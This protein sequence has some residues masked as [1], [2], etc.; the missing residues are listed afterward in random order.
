VTQRGLW[1]LAVG[2][3]A[4][5]VFVGTCLG[6]RIAVSDDADSRWV[7]YLALAQSMLLFDT[8]VIVVV[9]TAAAWRQVEVLQVQRSDQNKPLVLTQGSDSDFTVRNIGPGAAVNVYVVA[10][11]G[12]DPD[13][14]EA[15]LIGALGAGGEVRPP[16]SY[17]GTPSPWHHI[18]ISEALHSRTQQWQ[19]SLNVVGEDGRVVVR[20]AD[21]ATKGHTS[22]DDFYKSHI[23]ML[24]SDLKRFA[25]ETKRPT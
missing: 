2:L 5:N 7:A 16:G 10:L 3:V 20:F 25:E 11:Y 19:A 9:Y 22:F 6:G 1:F 18:V 12:Y 14:T 23:A 8:L 13:Q 15:K 21:F 4:A 17:F 24:V